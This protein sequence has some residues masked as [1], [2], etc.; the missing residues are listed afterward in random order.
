MI[1]TDTVRVRLIR[2]AATLAA[3]LAVPVLLALASQRLAERPGP[4]RLSVTSVRLEVS[5][6]ATA[7]AA[8]VQPRPETGP[9]NQI[10]PSAEPRGRSTPAVTRVPAPPGPVAEDNADDQIGDD[11]S[12]DDGGDDDG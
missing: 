3:L 8:P 1:E 10:V 12:G 2:R 11:G 4:P 6:S 5:A 9:P 7:T